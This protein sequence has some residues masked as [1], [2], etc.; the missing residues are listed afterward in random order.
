MATAG[1]RRIRVRSLVAAGVC[2]ALGLGLQ[3]IHR[4]PVV[5]VLGSAFDPVDL[6]AYAAGALLAWLVQLVVVDRPRVRSL[7]GEA[8]N[9]S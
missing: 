2:L 8:A 3:L 1:S 5:D 7:S 9:P 4:T 6:V